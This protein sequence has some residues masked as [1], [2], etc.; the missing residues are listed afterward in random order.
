LPSITS[1]LVQ[2][3]REQSSWHRSRDFGRRNSLV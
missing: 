1:D 2:F 3:D